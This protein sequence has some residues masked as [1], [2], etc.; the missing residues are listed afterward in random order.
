MILRQMTDH[1]CS[2]NPLPSILGCRPFLELRIIFRC[3]F[4]LV[5]FNFLGE[6]VYVRLHALAD[7]ETADGLWLGPG[8]ANQHLSHC[9]WVDSGDGPEFGWTLA[10][11]KI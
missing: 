7:L 8:M 11:G 9:C 5:F 1:S 3:S 10:M 4:P 6:P 2:H